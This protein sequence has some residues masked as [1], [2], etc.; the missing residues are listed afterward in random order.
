LRIKLDELQ[1]A[2]KIID[3]VA[4]SD[5]IVSSQFVRMQRSGNALRMTLTGALWADATIKSSDSGK[6]TTYAD[7]RAMKAFLSTAVGPDVELFFKDKLTLKAGQRLEIPS[8]TSI[9]GYE[10]WSPKNS[11]DL[12][13]LQTA[14]LKT[15]IRFLPRMSGMDHVDA[16]YF[17]K[18]Y[19]MLATD[20]LAMFAALGVGAAS[21]FFLPSAVAK[22]LAGGGKL[23]T[24]DKGAGADMLK[25]FVYQPRSTELNNY[26][27]TSSKAA[28]DAAL[29]AD[30]V[31]KIKVGELLTVVRTASQFL[32]DKNEVAQVSNSAGDLT[33]G[34]GLTVAVD[35]PAGKFERV[36]PIIGA[37]KLKDTVGWPLKPLTPWMEFVSAVKDDA[38]V[39]YVRVS[40]ATSASGF[41]FTNGKHSYVLVVA[42]I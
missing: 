7:R 15:G 36:L 12:T 42:D 28:I 14:V 10:N 18:G 13:D 40:L 22:V 19:G 1:T 31:A 2:F 6:W 33:K 37:S 5:A 16:I 9:S 38:E 26:P 11:F 3:N 39:E 20:T 25:G 23:A 30:V 27:L 35:L 29:K 21:D 24:D 32:L 34:K 41:R 8:R 4:A 17:G